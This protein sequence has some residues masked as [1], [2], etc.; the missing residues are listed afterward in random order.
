MNRCTG[1]RRQLSSSSSSGG[2]SGRSGAEATD[3]E[4]ARGG[5]GSRRHRPVAGGGRSGRSLPL[6]LSPVEGGG[7]DPGGGR[8]G[9]AVDTWSNCPDTFGLTS[10]PVPTALF[11]DR[12]HY[13]LFSQ[14]TF[15]FD[16]Y[17]SHRLNHHMISQNH[18]LW[19]QFLIKLSVIILFVQE[20]LPGFSSVPVAPLYCSE[21][22]S[23]P[24]RAPAMLFG[25]LGT[26]LLSNVIRS[27]SPHKMLLF[28]LQWKTLVPG[29]M[30]EQMENCRGLLDARIRLLQSEDGIG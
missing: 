10:H 17:S 14:Q 22:L 4:R 19:S 13:S 3:G 25:K 12:K 16:N 5:D 2:R 8:S 28:L 23:H 18:A 9:A 1:R 21:P 30:V 15:T 6:P 29:K 20:F 7:G 24:L 11:T 26:E 27:I